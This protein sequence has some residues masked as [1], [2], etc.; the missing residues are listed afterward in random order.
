VRS[1]LLCCD[2]NRTSKHVTHVHPP[3]SASA[4]NVHSSGV[5]AAPPLSCLTP[6]RSLVSFAAYLQSVH[7]SL[8]AGCIDLSVVKVQ[9]L[10]RT[11]ELRADSNAHRTN[12]NAVHHNTCLL[13]PL[14]RC[15]HHCP[16][17]FACLSSNSI[18]HR[19]TH[20]L[21]SKPLPPLQRRLCQETSE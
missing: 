17:T 21:P 3:L 1:V 13:Q 8:S 16:H 20:S 14:F 4:F 15:C 12:T 18:T 5:S 7:H 19:P 9:R 6:R 10:K 2:H 11:V